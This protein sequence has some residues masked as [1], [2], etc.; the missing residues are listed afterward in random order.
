MTYT[1]AALIVLTNHG[2]QSAGTI[3]LIVLIPVLLLAIVVLIL[4]TIA[5]LAQMFVETLIEE[6][7]R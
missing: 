3:A 2:Q 5:R 4:G 6:T 7:D 1:D